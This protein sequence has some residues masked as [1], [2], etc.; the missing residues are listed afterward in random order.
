MEFSKKTAKKIQ[1]LNRIEPHSMLSIRV[2]CAGETLCASA[3]NVEEA[4]DGYFQIGSNTK[5]YTAALI[6][7]LAE[8]GKLGFGD[9]ISQYIDLNGKY[10]YPTIEN[11]LTHHGYR[12]VLS[13][14]FVWNW[15]FRRHLL[16]HN[17]YRGKDSAALLEYLRIK[18]PPRKLF[19]FYSDLNYAILGLIIEKIC[20]KPYEDAM[21]AFIRDDLKLSHTTFRPK[22]GR[23]LDSYHRKKNS[24]RLAWERGDIYMAAGGLYATADDAFRFV[25]LALD[26][27][28]SYVNETLKKRRTILFGK[29]KLGVGF[30][31]HCY[32][33]GKYFFHKGGVVC[34]RTNCFLDV[35]QKIC[36]SVLA[37]VMG[38]KRSNTTTIGMSL[39][40]DAKE[41]IRNR[42]DPGALAATDHPKAK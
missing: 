21:E 1:E 27:D 15:L 7:K 39:Y 11:L 30:G 29:L 10:S 12:P 26:G 4:E 5:L 9:S 20:G 36:V 13:K 34:F 24:G 23:V 31:W 32:I 38:D 16:F 35:K 22:D 3:G 40:K 19:Y 28:L 2:Y 41:A 42:R 14:R 37:N 33:N 18:K 8:E 25:K 17:V 6:C